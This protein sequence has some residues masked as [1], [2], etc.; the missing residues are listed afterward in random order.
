MRLSGPEQRELFGERKGGN[1][2]RKEHLE[3]NK[4]NKVGNETFDKS[5]PTHRNTNCNRDRELVIPS[6][7]LFA[8]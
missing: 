5:Y 2:N 6:A 1:T 4:K 3:G 8:L 7:L